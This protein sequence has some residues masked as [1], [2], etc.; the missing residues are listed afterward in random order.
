[1]DLAEDLI[2]LSG[3]EPGKDDQIEFAGICPGEKLSEAS[4]DEGLEYDETSHPDIVP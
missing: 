2:R 4:W 3:F 1:M